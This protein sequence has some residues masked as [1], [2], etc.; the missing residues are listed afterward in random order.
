MSRILNEIRRATRDTSTL[1]II[2]GVIAEDAADPRART[3]DMVMLTVTGGRER[4]ASEFSELLARAGFSLA[5]V[6][7]T[8]SPMRI[9]E[10][11]PR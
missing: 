3:L 6:V 2:E 11:R 5:R 1:L 8:A 7:D 10:A 9:V 4:T